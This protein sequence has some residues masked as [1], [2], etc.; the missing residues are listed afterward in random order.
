MRLLTIALN[1]IYHVL[2]MKLAIVFIL[3]LVVVLVTV[4]FGLKSDGT[5]KG[6]VQI[7]LAYSLGVLNIILS[8]LTL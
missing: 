3:F 6:K 4:S 5:Q 2:R 7:T 8:L 1:T